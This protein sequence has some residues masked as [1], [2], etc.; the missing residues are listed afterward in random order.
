MWKKNQKVHKKQRQVIQ[1]HK[2]TIPGSDRSAYSLNNT[3]LTKKD[4]LPTNV[5]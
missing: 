4:L 2:G 3:A 5:A 1:W